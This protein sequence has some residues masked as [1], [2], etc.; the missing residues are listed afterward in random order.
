MLIET[1]SQSKGSS[2]K[3]SFKDDTESEIDDDLPSKSNYKALGK[4]NIKSK[5]QIDVNSDSELMY[6]F[7]DVEHRHP[8]KSKR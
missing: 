5:S 6:S 7:E 4:K 3:N 8:N 1:P 2:S